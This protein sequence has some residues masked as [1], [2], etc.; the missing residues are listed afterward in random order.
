MSIPKPDAESRAFFDSLVPDDP[1][2]KVRPMFGNF[3]AFVNGNMFLTLLGSQVA[4]RLGDED[5]A[6]LLREKG[7]GLFEPMP[8]RPMKEYATLPEAWR[9][10]RGKAEAWTDRSFQWAA[11]LPPKKK[12]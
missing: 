1:R 12:K 3:A 11:A 9:K 8:G 2:V 6:E 5:R 10:R 7:S 4:V